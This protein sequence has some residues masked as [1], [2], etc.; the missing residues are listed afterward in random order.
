MP[1]PISPTYTEVIVGPPPQS[2]N[3]YL[4]PYNPSRQQIFHVPTALLR[5]HAGVFTRSRISPVRLP[6]INPHIFDDFLSYTRSSIYSPHTRASGLDIITQLLYGWLLGEHFAAPGF[7]DAAFA[8]LYSELEFAV[9]E[10]RIPPPVAVPASIDGVD[11]NSW[12]PNL[13]AD[14][15]ARRRNTNGERHRRFPAV[16]DA[17]HVAFVC[18]R[19]PPGSLLRKLLFDATAALFDREQADRVV[20]LFTQWRSTRSIPISMQNRSADGRM[21]TSG[22]SLKL[23]RGGISGK[24]GAWVHLCADHP[25][26]QQVLSRSIPILNEHRG[27]NLQGVGEYI[28]GFGVSGQ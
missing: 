18:A 11:M 15:R 4:R 21:I 24:E 20:A 28:P 5:K 9:R 19:S 22:V 27:A 16:I 13:I 17:Y 8:K 26:F 6:N 7:R 2:S 25:D 23:E 3:P 14:A 1:P 12:T 10:R